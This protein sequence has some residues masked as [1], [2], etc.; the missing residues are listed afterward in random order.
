MEQNGRVLITRITGP[1]PY[2]TLML[3]YMSLNIYQLKA[4][5]ILNLFIYAQ[6]YLDHIL[7]IEMP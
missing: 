7:A 4:A 5:G 2:L 6:I 3:P 1:L